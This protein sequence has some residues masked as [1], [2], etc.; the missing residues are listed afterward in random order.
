MRPNMHAAGLCGRR[1][2][3]AFS[4]TIF[5]L[6]PFFVT[7]TLSR[8]TAP[9]TEEHRWDWRFVQPQAWL[10]S[11]CVDLHLDRILRA[12]AHQRTAGETGGGERFRCRR[13]MDYDGHGLSPGWMF[14]PLEQR[15]FNNRQPPTSGRSRPP[16]VAGRLSADGEE[17]P[18]VA[19]HSDGPHL[20]RYHTPHAASASLPVDPPS[21]GGRLTSRWRERG[22][23]PPGCGEGLSHQYL[24]TER[25]TLPSCMRSAWL[26]WSERA[27]RLRHELVDLRSSPARVAVGITQ[28]CRTG[29]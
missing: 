4:S 21:A 14:S 18:G 24:I 6:P 13:R 29:P 20:L 9:T 17:H 23:S 16:S 8:G 15:W 11:T 5:S 12:V 2:M 3:V 10:C 27:A 22:Q 28:G 7:E 1:W 19:L 26:I 25:I